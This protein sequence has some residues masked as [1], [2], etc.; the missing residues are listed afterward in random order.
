MN[1]STSRRTVET[2]EEVLLL[3]DIIQT[4]DGAEGFKKLV[5]SSEFG[6]VAQFRKGRKEP[7]QRAL[8]QYRTSQDW[9]A[10]YDMCKACLSEKDDAGQPNL[11]ACDVTIWKQLIEAAGH[12]RA[13]KPG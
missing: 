8:E 5:A 4:H 6:P 10:I 9:I 3:Y 2:E 12:L 1:P 7:L 13:L 11:L